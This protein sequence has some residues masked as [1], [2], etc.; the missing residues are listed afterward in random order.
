MSGAALRR[1]RKSLGLTQVGLAQLLAVDSNTLAR[2]E[3]DV[4]PIS[5]PVALS[6][7]MLVEKHKRRS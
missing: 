7:R 3:R 1:L 4:L 5:G 6:V 2:W